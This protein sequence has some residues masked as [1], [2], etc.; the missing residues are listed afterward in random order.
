MI[1]TFDRPSSC[2]FVRLTLKLCNL[3]RSQEHAQ[4]QRVEQ[5]K[6]SGRKSKFK[7]ACK[8]VPAAVGTVVSLPLTLLGLP[9]VLVS[10]DKLVGIFGVLLMAPTLMCA[11]ATLDSF[12][13]ATA[14]NLR[15]YTHY[16]EAKQ[17]HECIQRM[18][19]ITEQYT[20]NAFRE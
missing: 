5:V 9:F 2:G 1:Q 16:K 4:S 17:I 3:L 6:P 12:Y 10:S 15:N 13:D 18:K 8:V 19:T 11:G 14:P 7:G 20:M